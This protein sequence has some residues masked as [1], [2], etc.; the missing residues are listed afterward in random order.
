[1]DKVYEA[2]VRRAEEI[3]AEL[4]ELNEFIALYRR[5]RYILGMDSPEHK[6]T[7]VGP[8]GSQGAGEDRG[9]GVGNDS[10]HSELQRKRVTDNPKPTDVVAQAVLVIMERE[11]PLS[12]RELHEALKERGM[13][14]KGADPVKTLGTMLWRSGQDA[15]VQLEGLGYWIKSEPYAPAGYHPPGLMNSVEEV[16]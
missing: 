16:I 7:L 14:V 6:G 15:L 10:A 13:E 8:A 11:K 3:Q 1:M 2:A 5:T 4:R 9:A 12:R